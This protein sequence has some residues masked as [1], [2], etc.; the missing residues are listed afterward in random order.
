MEAEFDRLLSTQWAFLH[1]DWPVV[2]RTKFHRTEIREVQDMRKVKDIVHQRLGTIPVFFFLSVIFGKRAYPGPYRNVEKGLLVLY[3][4]LKGVAISDMGEFMPKSSFHDVFKDFFARDQHILDAQLNACLDSM[5][6]SIKL[7]LLTARSINPVS[8]KHITLH[9]DGHD[10]RVAYPKADKASLYSYKLKKSGF[11]TQVC[12]DMN[13]M[14]VFVSQPAECRDFNDGTML[15]RRAIEKK[16]DRLD[17]I[18]VDGGYTQHLPGITNSSELLAPKNFSSPIRKPRGIELTN[19]EKRHN[20]MFGSFRSRIESYFGDMQTTFSKFS[21]STVNQ[22][23]MHHS[24]WTQ[25]EFEYPDDSEQSAMQPTSPSLK[26]RVNEAR[27]LA[28]LQDTF[29]NL[30]AA[31]ADGDLDMEDDP[32]TENTYEVQKIVGHRGEGEAREYH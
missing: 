1:Q 2:K 12:C 17:C 18:A 28:R 22:T 13:S 30:A 19:A 15:S 16:I 32:E 9:L 20:D 14:A 7:R 3:M 23:E 25:D 11:R 24:L 26:A 29:L 8:F 5:C 27:S 21:H 6:S 10:S 31:P 4:L